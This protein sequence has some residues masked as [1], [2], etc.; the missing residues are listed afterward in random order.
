MA[1]ASTGTGVGSSDG[2]PPARGAHRRLRAV[3][4]RAVARAT[5]G[6]QTEKG[7]TTIADTVV[8]K[9]ASIATREVGGVYE[10]GGG[11]GARGRFGGAAGRDR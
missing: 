4:W 1:E 8:T 6:L 7:A 11:D 2:G 9:V 3:G 5:G 10:L